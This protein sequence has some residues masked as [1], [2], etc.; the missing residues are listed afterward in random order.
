MHCHRVAG[1]CIV[2]SLVILTLG[3][4]QAGASEFER[5]PP[6]QAEGENG[7]LVAHPGN[8]ILEPAG[9]PVRQAVWL[10]GRDAPSPFAD[11]APPRLIELASWSETPALPLLDD[12]GTPSLKSIELGTATKEP[13]YH[14]DPYSVCYTPPYWTVQADALMLWR[15]G[16][17]DIKIVEEGTGTP[18]RG[19]RD[20]LLTTDA[21]QQDPAWGPRL[22]IGHLFDDSH[23]VEVT[24]FGLNYWSSQAAFDGADG[25]G[26]SFMNIDVPFD[27][28]IT[29]DFDGAQYV[30]ATYASRIQ[31]V[32]MNV[33]TD[34]R[35]DLNRT[36][37]YPWYRYVDFLVGFRYFRL[38]EE[39]DLA[40][41]DAGQTSN[42][43]IDATNDMV[44]GQLGVITGTYC[45]HS[46]RWEVVSKAGIYTNF[47]KQ[48]TL[49][50][51]D[52]NTVLLRDFTTRDEEI[53]FLGELDFEVA[54]DLN[55]NT[56]LTVGYAL[57]WL[58]GVALAPEQLDFTTT[59]TSGSAL[60]QNG[61]V[62]FHG[63]FA[64]FEFSH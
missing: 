50:G 35:W 9:H 53:A 11:G 24:Y 49:L 48:S 28:N 58:D 51:D 6:V 64:G 8:V 60:N 44:G 45:S 15:T 63:L 56:A 62:L 46:I 32:E 5:F 13:G 61:G 17:R 18:P 55:A 29:S 16:S 41:T 26:F 47:G 31:S 40:S 10:E 38:S 30:S 57:V 43:L 2:F 27:E 36:T 25:V 52:N 1:R 22:T 21:L 33:R 39:F 7:L 20:A 37:G 23:R 42:Y 12:A 54:Y 34:D 4:L 14:W 3:Q 19:Q 59:P